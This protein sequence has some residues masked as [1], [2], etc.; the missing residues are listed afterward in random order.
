LAQCRVIGTTQSQQS[1]ALF[2]THVQT[3]VPVVAALI[4]ALPG[5]WC[6]SPPATQFTAVNCG[7]TNSTTS[8]LEVDSKPLAQ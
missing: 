2:L 1:L 6:P 3:R 5:W 7:R 4:A 8:T